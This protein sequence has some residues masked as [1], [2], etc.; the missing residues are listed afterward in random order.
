MARLIFSRPNRPVESRS[1]DL[2]R[3]V[4][5]GSLQHFPRKEGK[6]TKKEVGGEDGA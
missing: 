3:Q 2:Q 1:W 5:V 6:V 4:G